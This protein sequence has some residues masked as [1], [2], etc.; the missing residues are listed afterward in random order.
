MGEYEEDQISELIQETEGA[1][2]VFMDTQGGITFLANA[3]NT[4]IEGKV[5]IEVYNESGQLMRSHQFY[6]AEPGAS[7]QL[8]SGVLSAGVYMVKVQ[9]VQETFIQK[10]VVQ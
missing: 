10:V 3:R 9:S 7:Y 5:L 8:P 2:R 6:G 1:V 4:A